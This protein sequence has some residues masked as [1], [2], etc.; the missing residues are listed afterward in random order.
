MGSGMEYAER[1]HIRIA[2][3]IVFAGLAAMLLMLLGLFGG[4]GYR[5]YSLKELGFVPH[6]RQG[7]ADARFKCDILY[8]PILYPVYW[9]MGR[10]HT[11]GTFSILYFPEGYT[12]GER[13]APIFGLGEKDRRDVYLM[14]MLMWGL[15]LNLFVLF[16]LTLTIEIVGQRGI[17]LVLFGGAVGFM[18][19]EILGVL[20]GTI[21]GSVV[22][23]VFLRLWPDN[24]ILLF[25]RS[26]W[27][28]KV[29]GNQNHRH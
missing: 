12:A 10:G 7:Y 19:S 5:L 11:N 14:N 3:K 28:E 9:I 20:I 16:S 2:R 24:P 13:A 25:W 1:R 22:A 4:V 21:A 17:Y 18:T 15:S 8:S 26:L 29:P 27:N 23:L 6:S